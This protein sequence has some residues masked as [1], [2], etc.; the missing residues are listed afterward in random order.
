MVRMYDFVTTRKDLTE[1]ELH[2]IPLRNLEIC[3]DNQIIWGTYP[4]VAHKKLVPSDIQFNFVCYE[5]YIDKFQFAIDKE[6]RLVENNKNSIK[7]YNIHIEWG[8][9]QTE[10]PYEE[11]TEELRNLMKEYSNEYTGARF[12]IT[13][14]NCGITDEE[15]YRRFPDLTARYNL[16]NKMNRDKLNMIFR[17]LG[18]NADTDFDQFAMKFGGITRQEFIDRIQGKKK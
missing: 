7:R 3:Q 15:L 5:D 2:D 14:H 11:V 8:F 4:L 17:Y 10:I 9:A 6:F 18:L 1:N 13:Y 16:L 12:S